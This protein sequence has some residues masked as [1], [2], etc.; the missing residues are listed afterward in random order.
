MAYIAIGSSYFAEWLGGTISWTL[1]F[2]AVSRGLDHIQVKIMLST[3]KT[4]V[5]GYLVAI[6]G[7]YFGMNATGGTEG[8]GT[9]AT[10]GVVA[11][12]FLVLI[13]NV[14]LVKLVEMAT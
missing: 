12:I 9:A 1:Y 8:V 14:F 6:T 3:L 4:I 10:R 5:F 13:A 7:C 11:S 2:N